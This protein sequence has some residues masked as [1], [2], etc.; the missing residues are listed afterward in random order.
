MVCLPS[1]E[2]QVLLWQEGTTLPMVSAA[3]GKGAPSTEL[4]LA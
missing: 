1:L 4:H 2:L 3:Q